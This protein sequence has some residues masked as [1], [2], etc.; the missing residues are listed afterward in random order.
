MGDYAERFVQLAGWLRRRAKDLHLLFISAR[1]L[2]PVILRGAH[3]SGVESL[4]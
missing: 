3:F 1:H 4:P 2:N